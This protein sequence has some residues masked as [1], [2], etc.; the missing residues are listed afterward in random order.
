MLTRRGVADQALTAIGAG[1]DRGREALETMMPAARGLARRRTPQWGLWA[2][3]GRPRSGELGPL[4]I[5]ACLAVGLTWIAL[6]RGRR[7]EAMRAGS[8]DRRRLREVMVSDIQTIHPSATLVEAAELMRDKNV[9]VLPVVDDGQVVG[10]ITDRDL[11]VRALTRRGVDPSTIRVMDCA[12][13][14]PIVAKEDWTPERAL[15]VMS[16]HQIGR[17]PVVE[18]HGHLVGMVT[19]SSLALRSRKPDETLAA[20]RNVALRSAR[21]SAA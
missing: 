7:R 12:T 8:P 19:L 15:L 13:N 18:D 21:D 4:L 5:G 10:V 2:A 17:L 3:F 16:E 9:G 20:A 14:N 6:D 11:V 1:L